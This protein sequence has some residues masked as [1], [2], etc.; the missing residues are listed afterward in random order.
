M[1]VGLSS[2]PPWKQVLLEKKRRQEEEDRKRHEEEEVRLSKMPAWKREILLKKQQQK[3]SLV[4]LGNTSP[5]R[6]STGDEGDSKSPRDE[7]I[8]HLDKPEDLSNSL[9]HSFNSDGSEVNT[10]E[11]H[12]IPIQHNPWLRTEL[13]K[14][15][16]R[17]PQPPSPRTDLDSSNHH[18]YSEQNHTWSETDGHHH[19]EPIMSNDQSEDV[20]NDEEVHYGRGFVNKL[21]RKFAHLSTGNLKQRTRKDINLSPKHSRSTDNIL[22]EVQKP[23]PRSIST[24]DDVDYFVKASIFS[25]P[26]ARSMENLSGRAKSP[27]KFEEEPEPEVEELTNLPRSISMG[28]DVSN[29]LPSNDVEG[30]SS[31]SYR[32][33]EHVFSTQRPTSSEIHEEELPP[34]NIVSATRSLFEGSSTPNMGSLKRNLS[35]E[36]MDSAHTQSH[37][38]DMD[39]MHDNPEQSHE[40][41]SDALA[42]HIGDPTHGYT[43]N[44]VDLNASHLSNH[45]SDEAL[46]SDGQDVLQGVRSTGKVWYSSGAEAIDTSSKGL[47]DQ[48]LPHGDSPETVLESRHYGDSR[49]LDTPATTDNQRANLSFLHDSKVQTSS[50]KQVDEPSSII[51]QKNQRNTDLSLTYERSNK[52]SIYTNSDSSPVKS[53]PWSK[54]RAAPEPPKGPD[55]RK[56]VAY[57]DLDN[58][59]RSAVDND[60]LATKSDRTKLH[61]DFSGSENNIESDGAAVD[62][63]HRNLNFPHNTENVLDNSPS[64]RDLYLPKKDAKPSLKLDLSGTQESVVDDDDEH[65]LKKN[66][67][68]SSA[69][70]SNP[71]QLSESTDS[72]IGSDS[73][74]AAA[75]D[76]R[77]KPA[78]PSS[79][80]PSLPPRPSPISNHVSNENKRPTPPNSLPDQKKNIPHQVRQGEG[81]KATPPSSINIAEAKNNL[82]NREG[83]DSA[84]S[85]KKSKRPAPGGPGMLLIRPASN[86]VSGGQPSNNEFIKLTTYNDVKTGSFEPAKKRSSYDNDDIPVTN[87]DDVLD[88]VQES[89]YT[90][91]SPRGG[92]IDS[93]TLR[94][95][96]AKKYEFINAEV[97]LGT[98][99]LK[100][101]RVKKVSF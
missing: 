52:D 21:R 50:S 87:I 20:F 100:K 19:H 7:R 18:D 57:I 68:P 25:P 64:Y 30:V 16:A 101:T 96:A 23:P 99:L 56:H 76:H 74:E 26:K 72:G 8:N 51:N 63:G 44:G 62:P 9:N 91:N 13:R 12:L 75:H 14:K 77:A 93:D 70:T 35:R 6:D 22:D 41:H 11:E 15:K 59:T 97:S 31:I 79:P 81:R 1:S 37:R 33:S 10:E 53:P 42:N 34:S 28:N 61:L 2:V 60:S 66:T 40:V 5:R 36:P 82:K 80:K 83:H 49:S 54:K 85:N 47:I 98:S 4:F 65:L 71:T 94:R 95:Q 55:L 78:L 17:A 92:E 38:H 88:D 43:A 39:Y 45:V 48:G 84:G 27:S 3:N 90:D 89:E 69:N 58:D 46:Q 67:F 24:S 29:H 32:D 73:T 86:L